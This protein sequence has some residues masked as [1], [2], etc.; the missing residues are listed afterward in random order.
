MI[1][2]DKIELGMNVEKI[3][4]APILNKIVKFHLKWFNVCEEDTEKSR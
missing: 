1:T 3:W 2:Q 4:V